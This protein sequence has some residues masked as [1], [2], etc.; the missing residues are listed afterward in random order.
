[1]AQETLELVP[2]LPYPNHGNTT[3]SWAMTIVLMVGA[4]I[5][6]V[7]FCLHSTVGFIAGLVVMLIGLGVGYGLK[8]AGYGQ[9][10][11]HTK[12]KHH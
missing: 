1:M 6:A 8:A 5:A 9:G 10:G 11:K 2:D 4:I 7:G 12:Y 3:A